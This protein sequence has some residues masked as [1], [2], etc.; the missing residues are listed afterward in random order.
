MAKEKGNK[1]RQKNK[2]NSVKKESSQDRP[3]PI[4]G[5][6]ASAGGLEAFEQFFS[7]MPTNNGIGFVL[8]PHLDPTHASMM[9]ELL[10]R[11]TKMQVTEA[12]DGMK[13][14]PDQV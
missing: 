12:K 2:R 7:A 8:I 10:R 11:V 1:T 13:V 6:G 5:I 3:F 9:T 4:V 14:E